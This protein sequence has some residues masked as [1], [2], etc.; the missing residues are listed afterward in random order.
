MSE[1]D[2]SC[3]FSGGK[4]RRVTFATTLA[5]SSAE[6]E[7]FTNISNSFMR[8]WSTPG[9]D[10]T[11]RSSRAPPIAI[12]GP[13][14]PMVNPREHQAHASSACDQKLVK[15]ERK[16]LTL[17]SRWRKHITKSERVKRSFNTIAERTCKMRN[18][19]PHRQNNALLLNLSVIT[20]YNI[21]S[22]IPG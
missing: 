17:R 14:K 16:V 20:G 4:Q 11:S 9:S 18:R 12:R 8:V 19:S 5:F 21:V 15:L 22:T 7:S 13:I 2:V 10:T 3:T 1:R 6:R